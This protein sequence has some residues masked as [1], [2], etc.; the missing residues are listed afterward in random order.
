MFFNVRLVHKKH[1]IRPCLMYHAA[2]KVEFQPFK[3]P[4]SQLTFFNF[5]KINTVLVIKKTSKHKDLQEFQFLHWGQCKKSH[6]LPAQSQLIEPKVGFFSASH[7]RVYLVP[8]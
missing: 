3:R 5:S 7:V 2:C 8:Y 4:Y 6:K 1:I